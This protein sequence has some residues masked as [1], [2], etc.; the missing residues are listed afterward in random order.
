METQNADQNISAR[1]KDLI[2]VIG[3]LIVCAICCIALLTGMFTWI[4]RADE[5]ANA[6]AT[7]TTASIVT[8]QANATLAAI[9]KTEE[10]AQ[11]EFVEQ[12]DNDSKDSWQN[13]PQNNIY[14]TGNM[15]L[16]DGVYQW[17]IT[18]IEKPFY[19]RVDYVASRGKTLR[20]YD[21]YVDTK[22]LESTSTSVCSGLAF[23]KSSAGGNQGSYIFIVCNDGRFNVF[24][25]AEEPHHISGWMDSSTIRPTD[26]NR[27]EVGARG[28]NF[29]F[30]INNVEVYEMTD[31]RQKDGEIALCVEVY[32]TNPV[33]ILFD[34]FGY[35]SR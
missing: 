8:Q 15:S 7:A 30:A 9:V 19:Y 1:K 14:W 34:N 10:Q 2:L 18:T 4:K 32:D 22:V 24:Y 23:R 20:D 5:T 6:N 13:G 29:T 27:L 35:Q 26:W 21:I 17:D 16:E 33:K 28:D 31:N 11:Y 12:F 25:H 3:M